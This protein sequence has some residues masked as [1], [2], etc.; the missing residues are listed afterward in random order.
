MAGKVIL[1]SDDDEIIVILNDVQKVHDIQEMI[2]R[3]EFKSRVLDSF[4]HELRTPLN[5]A[6]NFLTSALS[7]PTLEEEVVQD[8]IKPSLSSLKL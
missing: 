3:D 6:I 8:Y 2:I 1:N 7:F 4:S 5:S